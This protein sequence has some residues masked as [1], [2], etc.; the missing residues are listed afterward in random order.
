MSYYE[1]NAKYKILCVANFTV[2]DKISPTFDAKATQRMVL[3]IKSTH[4]SLDRFCKTE[5]ALPSLKGT[6]H[7]ILYMLVSILLPLMSF[8]TRP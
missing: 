3:T 5:V 7:S 2:H 6:A 4:P 8:F 1:N